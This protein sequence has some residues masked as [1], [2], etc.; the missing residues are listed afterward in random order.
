MELTLTSP[1]TVRRRASRP[2]P[3]GRPLRVFRKPDRLRPPSVNVAASQLP[4]KPLD[5][6]SREP[7]VYYCTAGQWLEQAWRAPNL[8]A[9]R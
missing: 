5:I 1:G 3:R 9:I 2:A 6:C 7:I 4:Q 8:G